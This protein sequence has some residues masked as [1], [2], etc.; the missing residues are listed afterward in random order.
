MTTH[1]QRSFVTDLANRLDEA[2]PLIQLIVGP[3]QVGKTKGIQQLIEQRTA[4]AHYA[5]ADDLLA[6][7]AQCLREQWQHARL[8]GSNALLAIDEIQKIPHWPE[9]VKAL[10]RNPPPSSR[11]F[12][13]RTCLSPRPLR[14]PP[15]AVR[16]SQRRGNRESRVARLS[17]Q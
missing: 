9:T 6:G 3:R 2:A 8:L 15:Q 7:D 4:P 16:G 13:S 14:A 1:Y 10:W 11:Q 17:A 5:S 12:E